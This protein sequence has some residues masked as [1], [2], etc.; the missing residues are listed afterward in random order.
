VQ[1]QLDL[2]FV[3]AFAIE[4]TMKIIV[5]GLI[6]PR[7]AYLKSAWNVL[8]FITILVGVFLV[9]ASDVNSQLSSLR[10]LRTLRA[11][12]PIRMASRAP[13]M[14]VRCCWHHDGVASYQ[15]FL[16]GT[17]RSQQLLACTSVERATPSL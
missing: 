5:Y 15:Q 4:A 11:L 14:K 2:S 7:N 1:A 10:S 9:F 16:S 3:I 8:D 6:M 12:R 17:L 13:G